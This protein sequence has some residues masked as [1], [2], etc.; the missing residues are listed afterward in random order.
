MLPVKELVE[1]A[2][3]RVQAL[4]FLGFGL[5]ALT[6]V[7]LTLVIGPASLLSASAGLVWGPV[8]G[9]AAVLVSATLA[10]VIAMLVGRY[11][12]Y[13]R[14]Q[15]FVARDPRMRAVV[16]AVADG[17]WRIV[18]L[19]R[20][21]PLLPFGVQNYLLS[22]TN[23]RVP[24]YAWATAVGILPSSALFVYLGSLGGGSEGG[25]LRWVLLGVGLVA[26]AL[27]VTVV[28]RRAQ[29]ALQQAT[30]EFTEEENLPS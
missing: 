14:V 4:G 13:Q 9:L 27:V 1:L 29:T 20:L 2:Q 10:S 3:A 28:T 22:V 12:A 8:T 5:F 30:G 26:T 18:I 6:Y 24:T 7:L 21:S 25:V 16:Q 11:L 15:T 19:L 23:I 17:S